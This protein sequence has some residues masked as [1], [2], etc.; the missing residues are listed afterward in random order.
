MAKTEKKTS[1]GSAP[2]A[3]EVGS[4]EEVQSAPAAATNKW[5]GLIPAG[6][7]LAL[8]AVAILLSLVTD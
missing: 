8:M 1:G 4:S 7:V 5:S 6:I 2:D 3:A